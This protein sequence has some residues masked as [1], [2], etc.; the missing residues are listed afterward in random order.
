MDSDDCSSKMSFYTATLSRA[1]PNNNSY[2]HMGSLL[3][4]SKSLLS[5][6]FDA[7]GNWASLGSNLGEEDPDALTSS[8]TM[9]RRMTR[10]RSLDDML[11]IDMR[12]RGVLKK[13][14]LKRRVGGSKFYTD[15]VRNELNKGNNLN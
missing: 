12:Q 9:T 1:L 2:N 15:E 8:M 4:D 5:N 10:S 6:A 7:S 13:S 3:S 11:D 14:T